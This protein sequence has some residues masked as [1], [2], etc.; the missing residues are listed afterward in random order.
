MTFQA[1]KSTESILRTLDVGLKSFCNLLFCVRCAIICEI[2][3]SS[4]AL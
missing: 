3:T 2:G 4:F 1:V